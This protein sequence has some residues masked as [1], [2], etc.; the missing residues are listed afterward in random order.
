MELS[1]LCYWKVSLDG[2]DGVSLFCGLRIHICFSQYFSSILCRL[3]LFSRLSK[4]S[5]L[6]TTKPM[7]WNILLTELLTEN[8]NIVGNQNMILSLFEVYCCVHCFSRKKL[9]V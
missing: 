5:Y 7:L 2:L 4:S 9:F 6:S 8:F 1:K 3:I